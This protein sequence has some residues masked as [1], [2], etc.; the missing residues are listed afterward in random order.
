MAREPLTTVLGAADLL[1]PTPQYTHA[2][3]QLDVAAA[4]RAELLK[5][6]AATVDRIDRARA[7]LAKARADQ[8]RLVAR[9]ITADPRRVN[10]Y[11]FPGP[12][13]RSD[14]AGAAKLSPVQLS[15]LMERYR[16]AMPQVKRARR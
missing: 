6:L 12:L 5:E 2:D 13:S 11:D 15:R 8:D 3:A 7:S 4:A 10:W 16:Q 1:A 9:A 14:V